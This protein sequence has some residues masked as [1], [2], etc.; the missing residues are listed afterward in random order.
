MNEVVG[1]RDQNSSPFFIK[2]AYGFS[3]MG[4]WINDPVVV[5]LGGVGVNGATPLVHLCDR[6]DV[7]RLGFLAGEWEVMESWLRAIK[8]S[9]QGSL[10]ADIGAAGGAYSL[11]AAAAR[12]DISVVAFEPD[13][14]SF[15][16]LITNIKL[17]RMERQVT[18]LQIALGAANNDS[19]PLYTDGANGTAPSL[20]DGKFKGSV[21]VRMRSL[22]YLVQEGII[23][24]PWAVKVDVEGGE[25]GP[26]GVFA[27]MQRLMERGSGPAHIFLETHQP[28]MVAQFGGTTEELLTMLERWGYRQ[29]FRYE[30]TRG[31]PIIH[32]TRRP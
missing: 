6:T 30:R 18:A 11:L 24:L 16:R 14:E 15:E 4:D 17:N 32:F 20:R 21:S 2:V 5:P 29:T 26:D 31:I 7:W 12:P 23:S 19:V 10:V 9:P 1:G 22:E 25:A 28:A 3:L 8:A 27:G 13:P